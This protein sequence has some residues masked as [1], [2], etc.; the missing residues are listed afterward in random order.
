MYGYVPVHVLPYLW[1]LFSTI[2]YNTWADTSLHHL[3]KNSMNKASRCFNQIPFTKCRACDSVKNTNILEKKCSQPFLI[4]QQRMRTIREA[5]YCSCYEVLC[6]LEPSEK[7]K[8]LTK[9]FGQ[10][11]RDIGP[12]VKKCSSII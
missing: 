7:R 10:H 11:L 1:Y 6:K 2:A 4:G 3:L 9:Y 8:E 12:I 5:Q